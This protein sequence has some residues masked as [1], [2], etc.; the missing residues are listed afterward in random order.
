MIRLLVSVR[1]VAEALIAARGGADFIDLKEPGQGAL[2]GLPVDTVAGI[3]A[4]LRAEQIS[5]PVSATIGD[6]VMTDL[7]AIRK[8][9]DAIGA[10]GVTY[11]KV[12]ITNEAAAG[13]VLEWL[14]QCGLPVIPVFIADCGLNPALVEQALALRFPGVM[15]DTADKLAG[16]LFDAVPLA[17]L[18]AFVAQ[19]RSAGVM[20]GVAGALRLADAARLVALAI[21]F[22]GFRS[23]VCVGDRAAALDAGRLGELVAAMKA[24]Q[25]QGQLLKP[26]SIDRVSPSSSDRTRAISAR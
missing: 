6:L 20:V 23:A 18:Q 13:A 17:E 11:V 26:L 5:L 14:A 10:C 19:A 9:V 16:S 7:A 24:A 1:S 22:A 25:L 8:Q 2:G 21:D 15:A 3:V 12:G 4:A